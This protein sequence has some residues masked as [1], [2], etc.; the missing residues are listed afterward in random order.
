LYFDDLVGYRR[1]LA[2][3]IEV[4]DGVMS[5]LAYTKAFGN[6][7]NDEQLKDLYLDAASNKKMT[8]LDTV[9]LQ[10]YLDGRKG[11]A[12]TWIQEEPRLKSLFD[13]FS[14]SIVEVYAGKKYKLVDKKVRPVYE[15]L[16]QKFRIV[17][18]IK[19]DLLA[20]MCQRVGICWS[21]K[22]TWTRCMIKGSSYPKK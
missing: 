21:E 10:A 1:E 8:K 6:V 12:P 18:E 19:G 22:N 7:F 3:Q 14:A 20:N 4:I 11:D 13:Q 2:I 16:P 5:V 17:H 15:D 9:I